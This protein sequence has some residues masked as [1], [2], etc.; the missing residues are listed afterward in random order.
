M[1]SLAATTRDGLSF[2]SAPRTMIS[3]QSCGARHAECAF[4]VTRI[5]PTQ[6]LARQH[7]RRFTL[8]ANR[9][10]E[11]FR[12]TR[13]FPLPMFELPCWTIDPCQIPARFEDAHRQRL[14]QIVCSQC[15][16]SMLAIARRNV[17]LPAPQKTTERQHGVTD[18]SASHI[19]H[20]FFDVAEILTL[21]VEY[22]IADQRIGTHQISCSWQSPECLI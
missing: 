14:V 16:V 22:I 12:S 13:E 10:E 5:S 2:V 11:S 21:L 3:R 9:R 8:P 18:L 6:S 20:D 15:R 1:L 19:Q 7:R 17:F 4:A